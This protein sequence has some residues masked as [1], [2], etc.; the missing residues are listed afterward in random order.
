MIQYEASY[1][2]HGSSQ[3]LVFR[4]HCMQINCSQSVEMKIRHC[5]KICQIYAT[6][7]ICWYRFGHEGQFKCLKNKFFF[8]NLVFVEYSLKELYFRAISLYIHKEK[9]KSTIETNAGGILERFVEGTFGRTWL[10]RFFHV[11]SKTYGV[12]VFEYF[13][14]GFFVMI[15]QLNFSI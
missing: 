8:E 1:P 2:M 15:F 9:I 10:A 5:K 11:Q 14:I 7:D 3:P 13:Q 12:A 4:E 6:G